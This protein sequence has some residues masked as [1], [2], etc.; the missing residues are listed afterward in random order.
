[1]EQLIILALIAEI[2]NSRGVRI[3]ICVPIF[4]I[5][6]RLGNPPGYSL[7]DHGYDV[8]WWLLPRVGAHIIPAPIQEDLHLLAAVL[9][10]EIRWRIEAYHSLSSAQRFS[11]ARS[12]LGYCAPA[13]EGKHPFE[14]TPAHGLPQRR[15]P[16]ISPPGAARG[17][18]AAARTSAMLT[19]RMR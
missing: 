1:M 13:W 10:L 9:A 19:A 8:G 17:P 18:A 11:V 7:P 14:T 6:Q 2:P 4:N 16:R 15:R 12:D 5:R 3:V